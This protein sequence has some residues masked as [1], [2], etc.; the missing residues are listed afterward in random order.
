MFILSLTFLTL[1][2]SLFV[3]FTKYRN[4]IENFLLNT[5]LSYVI[6][7][8]YCYVRGEALMIITASKRKAY[9]NKIVHTRA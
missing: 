2:V 4:K 6:F 9:E 3:S 1:S 7:L 8:E 5:T